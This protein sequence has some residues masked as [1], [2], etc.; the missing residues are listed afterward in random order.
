[1]GRIKRIY[2]TRGVY[3]ICIRGNNKQTILKGVEDK[4][5]FLE[6]LAK[7]RKR[8]GFK[9]YGYAIMNNHAHLVMEANEKSNI[10]KIMQAITL[11]YSKKFRSKYNYVGYVWQGRFRSKVID[12]DRYIVECLDY[13]HNNPVRAEMVQYAK[14]YPWSS[15]C[16]YNDNASGNRKSM[17]IIDVFEL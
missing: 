11:S 4:E 7:Y 8:F 17:D 15:Y 1:M 16:A 13:I 14:D 9:L 3:H 12:A 5:A 6:T 2:F 10:S